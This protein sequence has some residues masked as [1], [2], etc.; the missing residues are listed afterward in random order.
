MLGY[1]YARTPPALVVALGVLV[2]AGFSVAF[3]LIREDAVAAIAY[4]WGLAS[5]REAPAQ[6]VET[7]T[8]RSRSTT[9]RVVVLDASS[10]RQTINVYDVE[11]FNKLV[12]GT[13]V[14]E[15]LVADRVVA[16]RIGANELPI[17]DNLAW[18]IGL[19]AGILTGLLVIVMGI[20]AGHANGFM[21]RGGV[22]SYQAST[23][24]LAEGLMFMAAAVL[25]F[26]AVSIY[27]I[28]LITSRLPPF[29]VVGSVIAAFTVAGVLLSTRM[30]RQTRALGVI[31]SRLTSAAL[32]T[33]LVVR[34]KNGQWDVSFI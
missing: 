11:L 28:E 14:R 15:R 4:Q 25:F 29:P 20:R 19:P 16:L 7:Y 21:T 10:S 6:V 23:A 24:G 17:Q 13:P 33:A 2:G 18:L 32:I 12:R 31:G 30:V 3:A 27:V 1:P 22:A 34:A 5:Y 26:S 8:R 9:T